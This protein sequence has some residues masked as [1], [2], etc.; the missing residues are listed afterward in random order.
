MTVY[1]PTSVGGTRIY[2]Y[3]DFRTLPGVFT[4]LV[5][6]KTFDPGVNE[7]LRKLLCDRNIGTIRADRTAAERLGRLDIQR[8]LG[9][10][11]SNPHQNIEYSIQEVAKAIGGHAVFFYSP[12]AGGKKTLWFIAGDANKRS[13]REFT[14]EYPLVSVNSPFQPGITID[15]V[16]DYIH[17][18]LMET[19]AESRAHRV[20]R[21][22][23]ERY[24]KVDPL[25]LAL[26]FEFMEQLEMPLPEEVNDLKKEGYI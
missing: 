8:L 17:E 9:S 23:E 5:G 20:Q 18:S 25:T 1:R 7:G 22:W 14:G 21:L 4:R 15:P 16:K 2:N 26:S 12:H 6:M 11:A 13:I 24:A 10:Y 3:I 19:V